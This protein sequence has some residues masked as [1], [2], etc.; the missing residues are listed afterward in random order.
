[1]RLASM[2]VGGQ[3][4]FGRFDPSGAG[5]SQAE[6]GGGNLGSFAPLERGLD[7]RMLL[8]PDAESALAF[9]RSVQVDAGEPF[10]VP[11][12]VAS[13]RDFITFEQHTA[14]SLRAVSGTS[15]IPSA[16]FEAP[17]FYFTNPHAL[18]G[19]GHPVP[20]PPGSERL[21]FELEVAA[22]IS[23]DGFNLSVDE[24]WDHIF[25]FTVFNDWSARDLQTREMKV[26]LGPTKG[27]DTATTV[28]PVVV[29]LGELAPRR[30]GDRFDL[31]MDVA[32]NGTPIA[33]D[34]LAN[35]AWSFAELV[36]YASR[37]TWVRQGDLIGSGTAGGGCL[38]EFWGWYGQDVLP[39][40]GV[41]DT[42]TMTVEDIGTISNQV[43]A[44]PELHPIPEA[45]RI[46][47]KQ[48]PLPEQG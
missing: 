30:Q 13:V 35:M 7:P 33:A 3:R 45:R 46:P 40:I 27:K 20:M 41:G 39:A 1:M 34:S 26:G 22:V 43:V 6:S 19:S 21:D 18:I 12:P 32:V 42:V 25:G 8:D 31:R 11:V 17:V 5:T 44:G 2:I 36:A 28:G 4:R 15:D 37:G 23:R 48:P 10:E 24:A 16:W 14:G 47:W 29:S 9:D 38:A